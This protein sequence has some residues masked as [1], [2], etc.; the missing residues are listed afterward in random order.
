MFSFKDNLFYI[1]DL[2]AI[3]IADH[4]ENTLILYDILATEKIKIENVLNALA[5]EQTKNAILKFMPIN[6]E[7]YEITI[8]KEANS[9]L[10]VMGD[11]EEHLKITS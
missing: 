3:A 11:K 7:N 10:M 1:R 9:T 4:E 6:S 5:T 8:F 2:N